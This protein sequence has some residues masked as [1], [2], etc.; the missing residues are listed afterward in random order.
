MKKTNFLKFAL[1]LV[2]AFVMTS[3][4]AQIL[5]DYSETEA[6]EPISYQ[7][8]GKT[9]RL[10]VMPDLVYSPTYIAATNANLGADARWTWTY[11][12]G[13]VTGAPATGAATAQNWV[14]FTNPSVGG[15]YNVTVVESNVLTGCAGAASNVLQVQVLPIPTAAI[16][17]GQA[18]NTWNVITAGKEYNK[19]AAALAEDITITLT[20]TG[21][22]AAAASYAYYVQ[23][24]V[25]VIDASDA[26]VASTEVISPFIDHPIATK[27]ATGTANGGTEVVTTG[28][29]PLATYDWDGAGPN[30][31]T[32]SRTKYEFTIMKP[33]DAALAAAE[34]VVSAIS[35]KS[36]WLTIDG[37]GDVITHPF[38]GVVTVVYI[39]NPA[40]ATGPI[41]H[42]SNTWAL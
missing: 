30:P 28:G 36:D 16:T 8:T 35:H 41:Y 42:I 17:G 14:T 3:T 25:V 5:V 23:K 27:Y 15:P 7:T 37:G 19:C 20:E 39:V 10:Y 29:M 6:T 31:A 11:P 26:E 24:R 4:F 33:T 22:P 1:T 18:N 9:F 34:G 2:L 38:T 12:A 13:L 32:A 21:V 40:P